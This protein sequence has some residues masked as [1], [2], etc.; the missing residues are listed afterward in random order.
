MS[1]PAPKALKV[2]RYDEDMAKNWEEDVDTLLLFYQWLQ[3]DSEDATVVLLIS[4]QLNTLKL[5]Q[6]TEF[7]P[8]V[9]SI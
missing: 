5:S 8:E 3:D 2:A 9:S 6:A 1:G 7:E 4:I